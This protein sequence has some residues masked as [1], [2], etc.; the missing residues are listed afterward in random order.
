MLTTLGIII[1]I[2]SLIF[3]GFFVG[4]TRLFGEEAVQ[5][6]TNFVLYLAIPALLFR[7]MARLEMPHGSAALI[8][9]AYFGAALALFFVS[10]MISRFLLRQSLEE[11]ALLAM[12]TVFSNTVLIGLPVIY[13]TLGEKGLLGVL[14]IISVHPLLLISLPTILIEIHRGKSGE[15][16]SRWLRTL[17]STALT[18]IRNPII[19]SM[20]AGLGYNAIGLP[21]PKIIDDIAALMGRAAAPVA[22]FAVGAS[23]SRYRIAGDL[24]DIAIIVSLKL[25]GLPLF[26]FVSAYYVFQLDPIWVAVAT[27]NASTPLGVNV[28][29][30]ARQYKLYV[31][32]SASAILVSTA[33]AWLTM[34]LLLSILA[35]I[36]P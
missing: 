11:Q 15:G 13:T 4:K 12:G 7:A 17:G 14:M 32:R 30:L 20:I 1:P 23:L 33:I 9:P 36:R 10:M 28:F 3:I 27:I 31:Q 22:L 5:G 21:L 19:L 2:F 26:V 29:V 34:A 18:L 6:L 24:R 8:I 25:L 35:P 16:G